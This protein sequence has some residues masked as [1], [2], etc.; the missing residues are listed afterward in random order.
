MADTNV[1]KEILVDA[2]WPHIEKL[3][4]EI[5]Y[6]S[7]RG[8]Q[9]GRFGSEDSDGGHLKREGWARRPRMKTWVMPSVGSQMAGPE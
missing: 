3:S 7:K 4:E 9:T 1:G 2:G 5:K 6:S 8:A